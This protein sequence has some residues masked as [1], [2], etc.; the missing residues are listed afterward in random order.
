[1]DQIKTKRTT[2]ITNFKARLTSAQVYHTWHVPLAEVGVER[3]SILKG[4]SVWAEKEESVRCENGPNKTTKDHHY[5]QLARQDLLPPKV[6]TLD[7]SHLLRSALNAL[8]FSKAVVFG[9]RKK[10]GQMWNG[11]NITTKDHYYQ[12]LAK[13]H[14]LFSKD[15]TLDT[16]HLLM[17]A[18]NALAFSKAVVFGRR[19][20]E[21]VRC[22]MDQLNTTKD[23][24]YQQLARQD[25][26]FCK[27]LTLDTS[28]L[29]MSALNFWAP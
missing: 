19:E 23:H 17:S 2:T 18:L 13:K 22:E 25:V 3:F 21:R 10:K 28:H 4:C 9:R 29:L 16:S 11:P 1:M 12:Q 20:E 6:V 27:F 5:Q 15:V 7:T 24:N 8:S 14:V 26:L